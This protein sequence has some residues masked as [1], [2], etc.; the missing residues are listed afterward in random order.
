MK[1]LLP[2]EWMGVGYC[3]LT[4]VFMALMAPRLVDPVGMLLMRGEWLAMTLLLWGAHQLLLRWN[5]GDRQLRCGSLSC[6]PS[7]LAVLARSA[8]QLVWLSKW[9]PDTYEFNR[10]FPNLDHLF[11]HAEQN[12]FGC[13][14]SLEFSRALPQA[15]WSEAFH[16]GYWI[17]FPM[18]VL[19]ILAIFWKE[20]KS[21][22]PA[23][24]FT[25]VPL[26]Q[27]VSTTVMACFFLYYLV[28]IFLPVAGPQFYFQAVGV[29]A[30][31]SGQF[32]SLG[33][34]FSAALSRQPR[35][36]LLPLGECH[37]GLRRAPHC[38]LSF[39]PH[40]H[41]DLHPADSTSPDTPI[42]LGVADSL[43]TALLRHGLYPGTLS[44]RFHR[45]VA[46][47]SF[48]PF[49]LARVRSPEAD[50]GRISHLFSRFYVCGQKRSRKFLPSTRFSLPLCAFL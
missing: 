13:Q 45:W 4:L 24:A 38:R 29:E 1:R 9:Y 35:R 8:G 18:I 7:M 37:T 22:T 16:F 42:G 40:R 39:Q 25:P 28:Y 48:G 47:G 32:P 31:E 14:P 33:T 11:A 44:G 21:H 12:I 26:F 27:Q 23:P 49:S 43:G 19:L 15:F 36:T 46:D 3:L 10:S 30:I 34:Y 6:S 50:F 2:I 20:L 5:L 41:L 17:Y